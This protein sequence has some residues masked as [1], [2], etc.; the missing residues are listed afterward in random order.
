MADPLSISA[1]IIAILH[2]TRVVVEYLGA[3]KDVSEDRRRILNEVTSISG[4]LYLLKERAERA[5]PGG[6]WTSTVEALDGPQGPLEQCRRALESLSSKLAPAEGLKKIGKALAWPFRKEEV[7]D[8]LHTIERQKTL[9]S[10]AL[11]N[12]HIG[13]SRA[14]SDDVVGLQEGVREVSKGIA[15]LRVGQ[16]RQES[17]HWDQESQ[18]VMAW[19]SPL[20]FS[21]KQ[22][23]VFGRHQE[24]TG[25]WLL[26]ADAF[27]NWLDG[28]E[29]TLWCPGIPGAGKTVLAS[30][31][32]DYL[33]QSCG[34]GNSAATCVYCSY[35]EQQ[36][37][38]PTNL[39]ASILQ[40]LIQREGH[41]SSEL[42][43]VYQHH[44][45]KQTRPTINECSKLLQAEVLGYSRVFVVV[46]ALD[47]C[48]E[49]TRDSL[50]TELR[51][52]HPTI[53]LLV[54]SRHIPTI[55]REFGN[56][57]RLEIQANDGDIRLYLESRIKKEGRLKR[58]VAAD[59]ALRDT[60]INTILARA[61]G[62]FLLAELH[63]DSLASKQNRRAIRLALQ[64]LP[65]GL[66][67]TYDAVIQRIC[68]QHKDDA[69]LAKQVLSWVCYTFRPLTV[70]E[71]Q[72]A[73]A[74]EPGEAELDKEAVP[75]EDILISVCAGIVAI[76]QESN[77][78]RLV[79]Y[80]AQQYLDRIRAKF[81][82]NAGIEIAKVCLTYL[83]FDGFG[84][85]SPGTVISRQ[86]YPF[87]AYALEHWANHTRGVAER[88]VPELV[89]KLLEQQQGRSRDFRFVNNTLTKRWVWYAR[90]TQGHSPALPL[91]ASFGLAETV[92]LLLEKGADIEAED[93]SGQR[94]LHTAAF[95]EH[96]EVVKVLLDNG[97]DIEAR[98]SSSR[99]ALHRAS[100]PGR[101]EV[102]R[103]LL[104]NG[105]D[106]EAKDSNSR[107][108]L[109]IAAVI[110]H[111]NVVQLLLDKG[112]D[113]ESRDCT[114]KTV[115]IA[116]ARNAKSGNSEVVQLLLERGADPEAKD[117]TG[118]TALDWA[119]KRQHF[120]VACQ[121]LT[122]FKK[123]GIAIPEDTDIA[124]MLLF[125]SSPPGVVICDRCD[126]TVSLSGS[127]YHCGI[128]RSDDFDLCQSCVDNG[129]L[130][131]GEKHELV[132]RNYLQSLSLVYQP[133]PI[134]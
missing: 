129:A 102:V 126:K 114:G 33:Q 9:F 53:S 101:I 121:L 74:V 12:D 67:D 17:R 70:Q 43:G 18:N 46:D 82:P 48:T 93:S 106:I 92:K 34:Q 107:T 26:G 39:V 50:L 84:S 90:A 134:A 117:S 58:H 51:G 65:E 29:R 56:V 83:S 19:L 85:I 24:G 31:I 130:C 30:I 25:E 115:L 36:D 100:F 127:Y 52:I 62:M 21:A 119:I 55:E 7:N 109:H 2:L 81:L 76:D 123:R 44:T 125:G 27:K 8:I 20:N 120:G 4:F 72:Q 5:P 91:A 89:L 87:F 98:D 80:T 40:Q 54:T 104:E 15:E 45:A 41:V 79:H 122:H 10:L 59:P 49:G 13:L 95:F 118:Q 131:D 1:S 94:A 105:V 73:L 69:H 116:A 3:V 60:V 37:Q 6:K 32:V 96:S 38:T 14:I 57:A 71:I 61:K 86:E 110:G 112:A 124:A 28:S 103:L 108:A 23:D 78:I 16:E 128:C 77:V 75:D 68:S 97:V 99:T 64:N 66:D 113:I 22:S 132:K 111:D 42:M 88:I 63:L 133:N 11:Q 35:G 47:E